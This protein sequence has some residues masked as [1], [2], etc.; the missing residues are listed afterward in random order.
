[1]PCV[2]FSATGQIYSTIHQRP[3]ILIGLCFLCRKY[4][5]LSGFFIEWLFTFWI[6]DCKGIPNIQLLEQMSC[7]VFCWED[8]E[9]PIVSCLIIEHSVC[10]SSLSLLSGIQDSYNFPSHRFNSPGK[11]STIDGN[12]KKH[13][14]QKKPLLF[15]QIRSGRIACFCLLP[16][17][18]DQ[19]NSCNIMFIA[20]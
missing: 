8:L 19:A 7:L 16:L 6:P 10:A 3:F 1:M 13:C 17:K 15:Q 14:Y 5:R 2:E 12:L 20:Y 11:S 4:S 9:N 18:I